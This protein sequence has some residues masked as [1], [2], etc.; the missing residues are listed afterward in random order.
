MQ[1][2]VDVLTLNYN[3]AS[4]TIEYVN[5]IKGYDNIDHILI[6]DNKSTDNSYEMLKSN[7]EDCENVEIVCADHNGGYGAGNNFGIRYLAERYKSEYILLSNPD[8]IIEKSVIS[9]LERFLRENSE[10][11]MVAPFMCDKDGDKQYNSAIRIPSCKRYILSMEMFYSKYVRAALY[12][13]IEESREDMLCVDSVSGSL[14]LVR[15]SDM[16]AYGMYDENVFLYC[17]ET[18]LGMKFRNAKRKVALLPQI[19]FI[20]NHSVSISKTYKKLIQRRKLCQK[21]QLYVIKHYYK[22]SPAMCWF[23][24]LVAGLA[25]VECRVYSG[26]KSLKCDNIQ[27]VHQLTPDRE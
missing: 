25:N 6:V 5:R 1:G 24:K 11:S 7:F 3:D 18:I 22:A 13:G 4:T 17:E 27:E 19:T 2:K 20:H 15:A 8:T 23:A 12:K 16:L 10:F 26:L 14:F 9:E 21:S